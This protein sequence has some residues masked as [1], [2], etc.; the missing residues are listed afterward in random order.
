M[1]YVLCSCHYYPFQRALGRT[2]FVQQRDTTY[3]SAAMNCVF[4]ILR[5]ASLLSIPYFHSAWKCDLKD[6]HTQTDDA[7]MSC[8]MQIV[9]LFSSI[10]TGSLCIQILLDVMVEKYWCSLLFGIKFH[11]K[12]IEISI[13]N[14]LSHFIIIFRMEFNWNL[15][16]WRNKG[17]KNA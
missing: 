5:A 11:R 16:P 8:F 1:H 13:F 10:D 14:G 17:V 7:L 4:C 15:S 12:K 9:L 2:L 3:A 6:L